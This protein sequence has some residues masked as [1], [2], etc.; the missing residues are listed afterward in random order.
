MMHDVGKIMV[1]EEILE[2]PRKLTDE[3]FTLVKQ[4]TRYGNHL[5]ETTP[6]ELF[7]LSSI[8]AYEHHEKRDGSG[9]IGLKG[10]E[11]NKVARCVSLA[12]VFDALIS[13]RPYKKAWKPKEVYDYIVQEGGKSFDP[14]VVDAFI[15]NYDKFLEINEKYPDSIKEESEKNIEKRSKIL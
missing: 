7:E 14:Q 1:N 15:K 4:H 9:Y 11:I 6:G 8:I 10:E 5:L 3:E 2:K 13:T 12:D